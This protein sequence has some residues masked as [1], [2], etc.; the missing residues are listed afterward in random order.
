MDGGG[1][2]DRLIDWSKDWGCHVHGHGALDHLK[3]SSCAHWVKDF[4]IDLAGN[5]A[6][7]NPNSE[8]KIV[9]PVE[10]RNQTRVAPIGRM[11]I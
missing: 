2:R 10:D 6:T 4:V 8:I 5:N 1:G 11:R 3:V 7:H 9:L